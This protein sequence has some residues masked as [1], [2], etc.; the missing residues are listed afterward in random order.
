MCDL[1]NLNETSSEK[2]EAQSEHL[3]SSWLLTETNNR[4]KS[5]INEWKMLFLFD[6]A[7]LE[8]VVS[9]LPSSRFFT[10]PHTNTSTRA[11]VCVVH[12]AAAEAWVPC[13]VALWSELTDGKAGCFFYTWSF[14]K[15][16]SI[17]VDTVGFTATLCWSSLFKASPNQKNPK[18][19][20]KHIAS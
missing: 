11:C 12:S 3:F 16:E 14:V 18:Y 6:A 13:S 10:K 5:W 1:N 7:H 20:K 9:L 8:L 4:L 15:L 19:Y 17:Y 2:L